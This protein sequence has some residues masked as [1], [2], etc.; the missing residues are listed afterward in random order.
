MWHIDGATI[1]GGL[2]AIVV[3]GPAALGRCVAGSWP[4]WATS[5]AT[6]RP[7]SCGATPSGTNYVWHLDG[8][9]ITGGVLTIV[10]QGLLPSVDATWSV[11][12]IGDFNGDGKSDIF[13]RNVDGTNYVWHVDGATINGGVL[14]I[15]SQGLLPSVRCDVDRR[16]PRR[17]QRRRQ[18][19][20]VLW[21]KSDG[22]NYVWHVDGATINGGVLS[23]PS[24]G[25][26][27]G[28]DTTWTVVATGDYNGDGKSDVFLRQRRRHQL[29]L[30]RRRRADQRRRARDREP[31]PA[32]RRRRAPGRVVGQGDYN[33]DGKADV[34]WRKDDGTNYVWHVDGA[35]ING[36]V[37]AIHEPGTAAGRGHELDGHQYEVAHAG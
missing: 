36:G 23:I 3:A 17:L 37:L 28:V 27:P 7:T 2:L 16:G 11:A 18:D 31:G 29:R 34:F 5:T 26:L 30:A 8:A 6:A 33:G 1:S 14:S 4:A 22:T 10:S 35:M 32:A 9:T 24:Q 20:D 19:G 15:V 25:L 13:W 21:R 12:G